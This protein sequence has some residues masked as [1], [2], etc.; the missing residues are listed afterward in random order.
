[1]ESIQTNKTTETNQIGLSF[2][3]RSSLNNRVV[4]N[5]IPIYSLI[6]TEV[7]IF[8]DSFES[9]YFIVTLACII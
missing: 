4:R 7:R 8:K 9:F 6:F 3:Q 5:G 1:M 2:T